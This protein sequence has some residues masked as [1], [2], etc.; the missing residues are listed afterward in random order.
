MDSLRQN[1][2]TIDSAIIV[3][4]QWVREAKTDQ[5]MENRQAYVDRLEAD[6]VAQQAELDARI[7]EQEKSRRR[8]EE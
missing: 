5:D 7:L 1:I 8:D 6:L 4:R 3:A 2:A